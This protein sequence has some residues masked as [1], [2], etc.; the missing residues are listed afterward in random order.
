MCCRFTVLEC[1]SHFF[2]LLKRSSDQCV[3]NNDLFHQLSN[4]D[5][6]FETT[7]LTD[8]NSL[9]D[10]TWRTEEI[11]LSSGKNQIIFQVDFYGMIYGNDINDR[12]VKIKSI[13]I[14]GM[15]HILANRW[16]RSRSES[17]T[18]TM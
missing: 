12:M 5:D 8:G 11:S 17:E 16:L 7:Y 10:E 1:A 15:F 18:W 13:E 6:N 4:Q 9:D 14:N 3:S 2:L